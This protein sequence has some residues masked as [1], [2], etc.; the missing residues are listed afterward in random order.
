MNAEERFRRFAASVYSV[1]M[2]L[3]VGMVYRPPSPINL[4]DALGRGL[5]RGSC[6]TTCSR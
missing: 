2:E 5:G 3:P 1:A 6:V 4:S